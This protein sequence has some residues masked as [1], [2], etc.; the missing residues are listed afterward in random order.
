MNLQNVTRR[1]AV[2]NNENL[3]TKQ[4]HHQSQSFKS[5]PQENINLYPREF[6]TDLTNVVTLD[7][8][9]KLTQKENQ[10]VFLFFNP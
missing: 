4:L 7:T 9:P 8:K 6:G 5:I 1:E 10:N 2:L 3:D